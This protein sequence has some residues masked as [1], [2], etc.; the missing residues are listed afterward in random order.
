MAS[1]KYLLLAGMVCLFASYGFSQR[2]G[3]SYDVKDSSVV[4]SKRMPQHTEFLNGTYNFPAKPRNQWEIGIKTGLLNVSGDIP[5]QL[6]FPS[7]GIHVRK[8]FGYIFS[9]RAEYWYGTGKGRTFNAAENFSRNSAWANN[10]SAA[11]SYSAPYHIGGNPD[12]T[13]SS[14]ALYFPGQPSRPYDVVYY[15]YKTHIQ[16][17]SIQGIVTLNNIRFHK[18]KTGFNFY[19]FGGL[20]GTVYDTKVNALNGTARVNFGG[21]SGGGFKNKKNN[22]KAPQNVIG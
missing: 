4:P 8:A 12:Y 22:Y 7:F 5:S 18:A 15:N 9:M 19:G 13:T 2:V 17:L 3:T 11:T 6:A 16:D 20:G 1:K 21:I 14:I 10:G